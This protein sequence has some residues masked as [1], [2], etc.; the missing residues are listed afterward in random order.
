MSQVVRLLLVWCLWPASNIHSSFWRFGPLALYWHIASHSHAVRSSLVFYVR[1]PWQHDATMVYCLQDSFDVEKQSTTFSIADC[2]WFPKYGAPQ[3]V[4][5]CV[6]V[7]MCKKLYNICIASKASYSHIQ[8]YH[9]QFICLI[10]LSNHLP[11]IYFWLTTMPTSSSSLSPLL[12]SFPTGSLSCRTSLGIFIMHLTAVNS[13]FQ[14]YCHGF[15]Y[16]VVQPLSRKPGSN[17]RSKFVR[18]LWHLPNELVP[19]R[20]KAFWNLTMGSP[21]SQ[22]VSGWILDQHRHFSSFNA[23]MRELITIQACVFTECESLS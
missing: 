23:N 21:P 5:Y 19:V 1:G 15:H 9:I 7:H 16:A 13:P 20:W 10:V 3:Y 6:L 12:E 8:Q 18:D 22:N 4:T 17:G 14:T 11:R 2:H